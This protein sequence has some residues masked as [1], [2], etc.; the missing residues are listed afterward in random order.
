[1][2]ENVSF[3]PL[4]TY[5]DDEEGELWRDDGREGGTSGASS[6]APM[7]VVRTSAHYGK[8]FTDAG[9]RTLQ[10]KKQ[11]F[12][13]DEMP[14]MCYVL[15]KISEPDIVEEGEAVREPVNSANPSEASSA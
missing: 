4:G 8:L 6:A 3:G 10:K 12:S 11:I 1:M 7:S 15:Q 9:L 14:M 2:G 5:L 13:A